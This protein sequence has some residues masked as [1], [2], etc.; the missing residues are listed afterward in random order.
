[1]MP[2]ETDRV[3]LRLRHAWMTLVIA[4]PIG[5]ECHDVGILVDQPFNIMGDQSD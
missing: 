2:A 3:H 4:H 5:H 1:M